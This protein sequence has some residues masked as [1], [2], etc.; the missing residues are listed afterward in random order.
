MSYELRVTNPYNY[1]H[2]TFKAETITEVKDLLRNYVFDG[3]VKLYEIKEIS[4]PC[5]FD[6]VEYNKLSDM[7][8][9]MLWDYA[10]VH[11]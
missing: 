1:G 9:K 5:E 2:K 6:K 4:L 8:R 7:Q 10:C 11:K 3:N